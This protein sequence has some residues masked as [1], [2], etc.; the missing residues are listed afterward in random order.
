MLNGVVGLVSTAV[1][2][3]LESGET[4]GVVGLT[5]TKTVSWEDWENREVMGDV[6]EVEE[7]GDIRDGLS[8]AMAL[9]EL[10][11][12][13]PT[14]EGRSVKVGIPYDVASVKDC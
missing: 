11:S 5:F 10:P 6:E 9:I 8:P 1:V 14:I 13:P 3:A 2:D 7:A 12:P 4:P